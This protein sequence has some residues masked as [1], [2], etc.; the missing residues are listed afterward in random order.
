MEMRPDWLWLF[1]AIK[2]IDFNFTDLVKESFL[3]NR[4]SYGG[5]SLEDLKNMNYEDY[6]NTV[7]Y[8]EKLESKNPDME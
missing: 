4:Q 2:K 1:D 5:I 7:K 6:W 8:A 3:V